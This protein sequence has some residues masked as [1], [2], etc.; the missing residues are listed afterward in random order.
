MKQYSIRLDAISPL[1][2]RADH[3]PGGSETARFISG[4]TF[5]GALAS[6]HRLFHK[7]QPGEFESLFLGGKIHYP[8]LYPANFGDEDV[9]DANWHVYPLPKTAQT[10]K[11]FQ[12]FYYIFPKE[13]KVVRGD[14][15]GVYDGLFDWAIFE[16]ASGGMGNRAPTTASLEILRAHKECQYAVLEAPEVR[17]GLPMDSFSGYYRREPFTDGHMISAKTEGTRLQTHTGINRKWGIVEESILY[18]R[19]VLDEGTIFWGLAKVPDELAKMFEEYIES[20]GRKGLVRIGTG[21]TRGLGKVT[22]GIEAI[23]EKD[24][25]ERLDDFEQRLKDFNDAFHAQAGGLQTDLKP[26]YFALTLHSPVI[27]YDEYLCYQQSINEK[28]LVERTGFLAETFKLVYQAASLRR[29]SGWNDLWGTPKP[30]EYAIDTGSVFLFSSTQAL[31]K[32]L[33]DRLFQLEEEGIGSRRGEGFGRVCISDPFHTTKG[34][35]Q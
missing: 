30:N 35:L 8:N 33:L 6:V 13:K 24:E 7:N 2:L 18:N 21:R 25:Q 22:L 23:D 19:E 34:E 17:C 5:A 20:I 10:C 4:T 3:A 1:A 12:G 32:N 11:R 29:V 15:H 28:T 31:D 27:L 9:E 26:F 14:R 16:M